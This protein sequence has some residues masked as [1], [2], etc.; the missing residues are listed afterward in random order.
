MTTYYVDYENGNDTIG[1]G[2]AWGTAW[3]TID[4]A[5]AEASAGDTIRVAKSPAPTLVGNATF[6]NKSTITLASAQTLTIDNCETAW[7]TGGDKVTPSRVTSTPY[8]KEGTYCAKMTIAAGIATDTLQAY[9]KISD[10]GID[11]SSYQKIS[12]WVYNSVV[13]S[14]SDRWYIALCSDDAGATP[15]D[16]F[17]IPALTIANKWQPLT[18]T[19]VGG[20]NLDNAIKSIAIYTGSDVT[21]VSGYLGLDNI[22]ACTTSGLNLQSLISKTSSEQSVFADDPWWAIMNIDGTTIM[23]DVGPTN[24]R[25]ALVRG[26]CGTTET[27]SLYK[28][29]CIQIYESDSPFAVVDSG[30]IYKGGYNTSN[31]NQDGETWF[32]GLNGGKIGFYPLTKNTI[33]FDRLGLARF[34]F[35]MISYKGHTHTITNIQVCDCDTGG[36]IIYDQ[37]AY[38]MTVENVKVVSSGYGMKIGPSLQRLKGNYIKAYSNRSHGVELATTTYSIELDNILSSNNGA[39]G[40]LLS[41]S[42]WANIGKIEIKDN[43][44]YGISSSAKLLTIS[45]LISSGNT[46]SAIHLSEESTIKITR[47]EI[48]DTTVLTNAITA[49]TN[50]YLAIGNFDSVST[51]H[52]MYFSYANVITEATDR[53][54]GTGIMWK[55]SLTNAVRDLFY[56]LKLPIAKIAVVADKLVTVKCYMKKSHATNVIGKLVC[57][58]YQLTGITADATDTKADDTDWEELEIT[59]TPTQA[60]VVEIQAWAYTDGTNTGSVYVEDMTITQA[61]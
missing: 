13:V 9:Y 21:G 7:T 5:T 40:L 42:S 16:T 15:V 11:L 30:I 60:G 58:G 3:K 27:V 57:S 1:D 2:L 54:D 36:I 41:S 61:D 55:I 35:G 4:K 23:L 38:R 43:A 46:T 44:T 50:G 47:G 56:I 20:G 45:H 34:N 28:R 31:S 37:G 17:L 6:T 12:L 48:G 29:E 18:L 33:T 51:D 52:R 14:G 22:I 10:T 25:P 32:D 59:F 19:K 24:S 26:Y 53:I 8:P 39:T 49:Y